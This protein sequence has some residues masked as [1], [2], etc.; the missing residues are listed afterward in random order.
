MLYKYK[1]FTQKDGIRHYQ[2]P[3][4]NNRRLPSSTTITGQLDKPA[5]VQWAANMTATYFQEEL[6]DKIQKGDLTIESVQ[7]MDLR[8]INKS[9]R[10]HH[11]KKKEEA[12]DLGTRVHHWINAYLKAEEGEDIQFDPDMEKAC[13]AF[14]EWYL[15][16]EVHAL[17]LNIDG[18][19]RKMI[20]LTV[21]SKEA[22]G[23][24][25]TLD[26]VA[27]V[28]NEEKTAHDLTLIDFK[29][30]KAIYTDMAM[31]V[32]SYFHAFEERFKKKVRRSA[33]VR[34]DKE[35]GFPE[36]C[37]LTD[38]ENDRGFRK[39]KLL[40]YLYHEDDFRRRLV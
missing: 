19:N 22:G 30:G 40:C 17:D 2:I 13:S 16:N 11:K 24:A 38:E 31:Q 14:M 35:L 21:W 27:Y 12:G 4:L 32:S 15:T 20:E 1:K 9:A 18:E 34:L 28:L 29:T 23:Y 33:I 3:E 25:G 39:F 10:L 5:L 8:D 7:R 6:I 36:Y 26:L 37:P